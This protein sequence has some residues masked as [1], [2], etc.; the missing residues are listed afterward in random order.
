MVLGATSR[1]RF[2]PRDGRDAEA[3][4][5]RRWFLEV[6]D[7]SERVGHLLARV[8]PTRHSG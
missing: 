7:D 1:A 6:A 4:V 8:K 2:S 5:E 3:R